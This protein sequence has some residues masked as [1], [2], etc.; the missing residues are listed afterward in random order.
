MKQPPLAP[1]ANQVLAN[2]TPD[3]RDRQQK[4]K[5]QQIQ[6]KNNQLHWNQNK[7]KT[8]IEIKSIPT[9]VGFGGLI[10]GA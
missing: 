3:G 4:Q 8:D 9:C 2:H 7:L 6:Y 10:V 1:S 5:Q